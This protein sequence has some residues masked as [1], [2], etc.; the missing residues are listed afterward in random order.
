MSC[1]ISFIF[2]CHFVSVIFFVVLCH[3]TFYCV[4][5]LSTYCMSYLSVIFVVL[6]DIYWCKFFISYFSNEINS[7]FQTLDDIGGKLLYFLTIFVYDFVML[8]LCYIYFNILNYHVTVLYKN[9]FRYQLPITVAHIVILFSIF[10]LHVIHSTK[11]GI[12]CTCT[13]WKMY[14]FV[15]SYIIMRIIIMRLLLW[16]DL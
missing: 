7:S 9:I 10:H 16:Y 3:Q 11:D 6:D 4:I 8:H 5:I 13:S 2:I 15:W 12:K 14:K 1:N